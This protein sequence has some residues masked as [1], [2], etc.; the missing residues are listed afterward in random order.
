MRSKLKFEVSEF[1]QARDNDRGR[2]HIYFDIKK[3]VKCIDDL[4]LQKEIEELIDPWEDKLYK[5]LKEKYSGG[6][7]ELLNQKYVDSFPLYYQVRIPLEVILKDIKYFE[8]MT[9]SLDT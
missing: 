6:V 8:K 9:S 2:L 4:E 7:A 3:Q 1:I 5:K